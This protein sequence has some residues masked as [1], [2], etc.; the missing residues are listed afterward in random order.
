[1]VLTFNQLQV[2]YIRLSSLSSLQ[3]QAYRYFAFMHIYSTVCSI[4]ELTS[5][6]FIVCVK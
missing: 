2:T 1:M 6:C 4:G 5:L 3:S